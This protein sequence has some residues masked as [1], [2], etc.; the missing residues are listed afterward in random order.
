MLDVGM[1][2]AASERRSREEVRCRD[3]GVDRAR[4][5]R[6]HLITTMESEKAGLK[7][8]LKGSVFC[9]ED[10]GE[11]MRAG[12]VGVRFFLDGARQYRV[13]EGCTRVVDQERDLHAGG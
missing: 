9:G 4:S 6:A 7:K 10:G 12:K 8:R 13:A 3:M 2:T 11:V 1:M 5:K